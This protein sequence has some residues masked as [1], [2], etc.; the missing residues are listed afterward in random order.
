MT[1]GRV[2]FDVTMARMNRMGTGT[3]TRKLVES[4]RPLMGNRLSTIEFGFA[5]PVVH[6]KTPRDRLATFA[7]DTWWTQVGVIDA[8]RACQANLVHVP[9]MLAPLRS[10]LPLVVTIYDL[11]I[12]RFPQKFRRWHRTFTR[13]LLPRLVQRV[14]AIVTISEA[15]KR[16]LVE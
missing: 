11:A 10:S 8:A 2:A 12:V 14:N 9:A 16:D 6:Q 4:L 15:T 3:Y 7:H 13:F 1:E 5:R